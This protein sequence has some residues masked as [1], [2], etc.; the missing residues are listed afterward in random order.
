[1][2]R[3]FSTKFISIML[4]F[5]I[6]SQLM[7]PMAV[8]AMNTD[9][10]EQDETQ[11]ELE[12]PGQTDPTEPTPA[13]KDVKVPKESEPIEIDEL[14]LMDGEYLIPI[15]ME[16][17]EEIIKV[18]PE[19]I[20][21][22]EAYIERIYNDD[23][24]I[25]ENFF[26]EPIK[27]KN[28]NDEWQ[29]TNPVIKE[30]A[31]RTGETVYISDESDV[32][33][34]FAENE[35]G[36]IV[37]TVQKDKYSVSLKPIE[38]GNKRSSGN[39]KFL[40]ITDKTETLQEMLKSNGNNNNNSEYNNGNSSANNK[41]NVNNN[42]NNYQSVNRNPNSY[43]NSG[44]KPIKE[45]TEF[46]EESYD[47]IK[48]EGIFSDSTDLVLQP[49]GRGVKEDIILNEYTDQEV[50]SFELELDNLYPVQRHD[51]SVFLL[52]KQ[53]YEIISVI[54]FPWMI[55][56]AEVATEVYHKIPIFYYIRPNF[57]QILLV[58]AGTTCSI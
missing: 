51:N 38:E 18:Q 7:C 55:D 39:I 12:I 36:N 2:T 33:L 48:Y 3:I 9:K 37:V 25:T 11:V 31:T 6:S 41:G 46:S 28:D 22:M 50:Y 15:T 19:E 20:K 16:Q 54:P 27:Y 23:E 53:T 40:E 1:M 21:D 10:F 47:A 43:T 13:P 17:F 14:N 29:Y 57:S 8:T 26:F 52:D 44:N 49:S 56:S 58:F 30:E 45:D 34:E 42:G 24:T 35:N 4:A 5:I 32:K